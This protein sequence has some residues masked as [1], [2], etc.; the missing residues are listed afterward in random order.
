[1]YPGPSFYRAKR[2]IV[3]VSCLSV[4]LSVTLVDCDDMRWNFS[5][6]ISYILALLFFSLQTPTSRIY[7]KGNT[8]KF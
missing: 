2:G 7:S 6:I 1:M 8:P 3:M 5:R 4:R